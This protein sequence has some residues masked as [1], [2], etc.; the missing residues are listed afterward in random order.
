VRGHTVQNPGADGGVTVRLS[1]A[2]V[3]VPVAGSGA[4]PVMATETV[5]FAGTGRDPRVSSSRC[6]VDIATYAL[7]VPAAD[8]VAAGAATAVT[9]VAP[10]TLPNAAM[11]ARTDRERI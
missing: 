4:L 11:T 10:T 1:T 3:T 7:V 6:D 2:A 9:R 8:T 5:P